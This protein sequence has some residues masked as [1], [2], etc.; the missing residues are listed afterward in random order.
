MDEVSGLILFIYLFFRK[1]IPEN[2]A[3]LISLHNNKFVIRNLDICFFEAVHDLYKT[4]RAGRG[5]VLE[6]SG[7]NKGS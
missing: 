7:L 1:M 2:M 6:V 5:I 4:V 3:L